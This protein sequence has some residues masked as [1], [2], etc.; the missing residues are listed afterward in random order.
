ML[1]DSQAKSLFNFIISVSRMHATASF[2]QDGTVLLIGGRL[3]PMKLCAQMVA[4]KW[5]CGIPDLEHILNSSRTE[6]NDEMLETNADIRE[7][8]HKHGD[9]ISAENSPEE[10]GSLN[11][12][13]EVKNSN[14][15]CKSAG[16]N[17]TSNCDNL[18]GAQKTVAENVNV[19]E[20][21]SK[22][23]SCVNHDE[24]KNN[25]LVKNLEKVK[26][27]GPGMSKGDNSGVLV[28]CC[29][30][31]QEGEMPCPRWRHSAITVEENG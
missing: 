10:N 9:K 25:N 5:N 22:N 18:H 3:S 14:F 31:K 19:S 1:R 20:N 12:E 23:A 8:K 4:L 13:N 28:E 16:D 21:D 24:N 6:H 26:V 2:L 29:V 27:N 17:R 11:S 7:T 30:V 15:D